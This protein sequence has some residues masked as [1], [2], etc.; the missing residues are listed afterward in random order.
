MRATTFARAWAVTRRDGMVLGFTDHDVMLEFDGISFRPNAGLKAGAL[1]VGT[2]LSVDNSEVIGALMDDAITEGDLQAGRWDGAE[3]RMWHVD[4]QNPGK[5]RLLFRGRL[6]EVASSDGAFRAELRGLS[7]ALA[8]G[9]GRV[10]QR[11]CSAVLGDAACGAD[12]ADAA[13]SVEAVVQ[14]CEGGRVFRFDAPEFDSGWFEGGVLQLLDGAAAELRGII[15]RD[16]VTAAGREVELW[17]GLG[18]CAAVGDRVRVIAG[19]DKR[20]ETCR[21]KFGNFLNFRGFPHLPTE[22]WLLAPQTRRRHG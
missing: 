13:F 16:E 21:V 22:D 9:H 14:A 10:Y 19:C 11:A 12:L 6:G 4:W 17:Q 5:R 1:A 8:G 20:S 3:L 15:R 2:G 18:R 7:E